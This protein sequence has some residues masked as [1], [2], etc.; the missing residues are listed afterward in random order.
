VNRRLWDGGEV[1]QLAQPVLFLNTAMSHS[2]FLLG[3]FQLFFIANLFISM[4]RGRV[5]TT[6]PWQATTM[7]WATP[8]PPLAHGNF[9]TAPRAYRSPYEYSVPGAAADFLPQSAADERV[10]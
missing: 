6:N 7:E 5:A 4:R 2:A 8:T 10:A 3:F 1:Y 9:E